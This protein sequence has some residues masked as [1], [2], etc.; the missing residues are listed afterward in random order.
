[1]ALDRS[2]I[3][4]FSD[5]TTEVVDVPE[6]GGSVHVRTMTGSERDRFEAEHIKDPS[7]DF[8]ARIVATTVC[9]ENGTRLFEPEDIPILGRKSCSAL[10]RITDVAVRLNGF[11][12]KDQ[13]ELAKN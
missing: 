9:D 1:M 7:K 2:T 4:A 12:K 6:W 5:L 10:D 11:S 3:L 13:E 8:R